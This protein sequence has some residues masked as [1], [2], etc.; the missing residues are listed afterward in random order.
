MSPQEV[1]IA[2]Q[3]MDVGS[4][5]CGW[6]SEPQHLGRS[7]SQHVLDELRV[8]GYSIVRDYTVAGRS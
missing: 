5:R 1:L 2:H 7:H 6:G 3:R 4:C 8:A